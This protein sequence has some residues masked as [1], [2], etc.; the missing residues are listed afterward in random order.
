L[1]ATTGPDGTPS[2]PVSGLWVSRGGAGRGAGRAGDRVAVRVAAG[3]V[4]ALL[5]AACGTALFDDV[6]PATATS[7]AAP[8]AF[9]HL[10]LPSTNDPPGI[11]TQGTP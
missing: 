11:G 5:G 6:Q 1:T 10:D 4:G 2:R 9:A 3:L 8:T 7:S